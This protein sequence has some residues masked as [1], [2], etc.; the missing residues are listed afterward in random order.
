MNG[1]Y[2][3]LARQLAYE[4][5]GPS[6]TFVNFLGYRFDLITGRVWP[7]QDQWS[8]LKQKVKFIKDWNSC[9]VRQFMSL[10]GLLTVTEKQVWSGCLRM[11]PIHCH[12]KQHWHVPEILDKMP[13]SPPSTGLV[14]GREK[15]GSRPTFA[16]SAS[17]FTSVY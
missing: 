9:M 3:P 1:C 12:L 10:I 14:V 16:P 13:C 2:K 7:T 11:I 17:C 4:I 6:W 8:T 5:P 15:R